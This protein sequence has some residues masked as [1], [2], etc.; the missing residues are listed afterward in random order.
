MSP[1]RRACGIQERDGRVAKDLVLLGWQEY[2]RG[3]NPGRHPDRGLLEPEDEKFRPQLSQHP[4]ERGQLDRDEEDHDPV[5]VLK[6]IIGHRLAE[7]SAP[8]SRRDQTRLDPPRSARIPGCVA[9]RVALRI[10]AQELVVSGPYGPDG[11][12][13]AN[14]R[15]GRLRAR[16]EPRGQGGRAAGEREA[17]AAG[18]PSEEVAGLLD[19]LDRLDKSLDR[20]DGTGLITGR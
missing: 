9:P 5:G 6:R 1:R 20:L 12:G 7:Q 10:L 11:L 8:I 19:A 14:A 13:P 4:V 15:V 18:E 16:L 3:E 2:G 17:A